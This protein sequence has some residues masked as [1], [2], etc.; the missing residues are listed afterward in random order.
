M[1]DII[2]PVL[3]EEILLIQSK[4]YYQKLSRKFN[5]V[6]VDG[7]SSDST[8]MLC[9]EIGAVVSSRKGRA[10]QKN[11]GVQR[12][13]NKYLLFLH[14]DVQVDCE[15]ITRALLR[16]KSSGKNVGVFKLKLKSDNLVFRIFEILVNFRAKYFKVLD[17]D[18]GLLISRE[19]FD[20]LGGFDDVGI[21]EDIL[22]GKKV[23]K[24]SDI[25]IFEDNVCV[26]CRKWQDNF[27]KTFFIYSRLYVLYWFCQMKPGLKK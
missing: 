9:K 17:G 2:I 25:L 18:L 1:L 21:F 15:S 20:K 10:I 7:Q 22:F 5:L 13:N 23:A 24:S 16:I 8:F 19:Y 11:L 3:N 4:S 12:S 27:L 6:F 14:A 26:S